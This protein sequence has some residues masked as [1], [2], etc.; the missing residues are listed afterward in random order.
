MGNIGKQA[1]TAESHPKEKSSS[2]Y[3]DLGGSWVREASP[4][5]RSRDFC[6]RLEGTRWEVG[7]LRP[8][9]AGLPE[10][11]RGVTST[12][13]SPASHT[14]AQP[15][16]KCPPTPNAPKRPPPGGF[17]EGRDSRGQGSGLVLPV[18]RS[19]SLLPDR[20]L[21]LRGV[22]ALPQQQGASNKRTSTNFPLRTRSSF[23]HLGPVSANS[24]SM[25]SET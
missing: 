7:N 22:R 3:Q 24:H 1:P 9:A 18:P 10:A 13:T 12:P 23:L 15:G 6:S 21:R 2:H 11:Q 14:P 19:P 20:G 17:S 16:L 5:P 25:E 8:G 4:H